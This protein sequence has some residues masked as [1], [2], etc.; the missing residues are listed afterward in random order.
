MISWTEEADSLLIKLWDEGGSFAFVRHGLHEAGFDVTRNA[1]AGRKNRLGESA[2]TRKTG[3]ATRKAR[4]IVRVP[5]KQRSK[6]VTAPKAAL[7]RRK[8]EAAELDELS[9]NAGVNYLDLRK[10]GCKALLDTRGDDKLP[11]CCGLPR[12]LDYNGKLSEYCQT[13]F[14]LYH[15]PSSPSVRKH[16]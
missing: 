5:L 6:P 1:I 3:R 15:Y 12:G 16:G 7:D 9:R 14:R 10:D 13:H 4:D 2:F 11:R 8:I